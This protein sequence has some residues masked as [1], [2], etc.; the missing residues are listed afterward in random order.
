MASDFRCE[1][2]LDLTLVTQ[3]KNVLRG[4]VDHHK[5]SQHGTKGGTT[6]MLAAY[7][8]AGAQ[9]EMQGDRQK[10]QADL[11]GLRI[12]TQTNVS[13]KSSKVG[14]QMAYMLH[15]SEPS[16]NPKLMCIGNMHIRIQ[17]RANLGHY[18][19]RPP[20]LI[21]AEYEVCVMF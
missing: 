17:Q 16:A 12:E 19:A 14:L 13:R 3:E 11:R 20:L 6:R 7:L 15:M 18:T 5:A 21:D 1:Q 10:I 2:L 4:T 8:D 9:I